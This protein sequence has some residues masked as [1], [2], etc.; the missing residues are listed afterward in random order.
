M[1]ASEAADAVTLRAINRIVLTF[2]MIL[3]RVIS[4]AGVSWMLLRS[5]IGICIA[6]VA[7]TTGATV[8]FW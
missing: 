4:F 2:S 6:L 8:G 7:T 5:R 1:I 3:T